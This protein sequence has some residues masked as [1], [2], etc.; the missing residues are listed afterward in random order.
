MLPSCHP[1]DEIAQ[2]LM[3]A[4]EVPRRIVNSNE[5]RTS[6]AVADVCGGARLWRLWLMLGWIDIRQRY[7]RAIIGPFWIT[8]SMGIMVG[9]LGVLY[10]SLFKLDITEFIPYL[11]AGFAVWFLISSTIN[12]GTFIFVQAEGMIR[13]TSLPISIHLYRL[14]WRNV[15]TFGHNIVVMLGVYVYFRFN[16]GMR[17]FFL[18][19][20]LLIVLVNLAAAVLLLGVI[21]ARFRDA[22]PI[23]SNLMQIAFFV[24]PILYRPDLLAGKLTVFAQWNPL[25]HLLEVVRAPLLGSI[26]SANTFLIL[27]VITSANWGFAFLFYRQFRSRIAFW[28]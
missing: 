17:V 12:E 4:S 27:I 7:R 21:C 26:P 28:L 18:I 23:I 22:P 13:N 10:S 14:I 9:T 8:I 6:Q 20:G 24:T 11:S 5:L 16:P 3:T 2:E 1:G 25:Y 19:P 15:I